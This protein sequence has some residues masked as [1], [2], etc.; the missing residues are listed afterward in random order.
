MLVESNSLNRENERNTR[1]TH[2]EQRK[3]DNA[4]HKIKQK[5]EMKLKRINSQKWNRRGK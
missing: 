3:E 1:K 5:K 4:R 2:A